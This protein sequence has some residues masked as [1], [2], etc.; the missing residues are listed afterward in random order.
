MA[1]VR[2]TV[3]LHA[4]LV[5]TSVPIV[6]P[7]VWVF[8]T[9]FKTSSDIIRATPTL[10]PERWTMENY[11]SLTTTAPFARFFLNSLLISG[12]STIF[13]IATCSAAGFVFAKYR[14]RGKNFFLLLI[15][16]TILIP[17][18]TYMIP[19][20]LLT[21]WLGWIDTYQG[22]IFPLIIM[23]SGIFFLRQNILGIPD[24]LLDA[25]RIDG[26]SEFGVYW[27]IILPLTVSPLAAVSIVNWV[28]TW[29]VFIWPLVVANR[30]EMFTMELGLM[31]FQRQFIT[32]Y[33]GI[34]AA[35]VVTILPVLVVFLLF[36][37]RIIEGVAYTGMKT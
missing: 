28:Y 27:R 26:A 37:T 2:R 14:F 1:G 10:L 35:T 33:G 36:R 12:V 31:Y 16:S 11:A 17:L 24:D 7:L 18:Q 22:M 30:E 20:Y 13:V 29:S 4:V 21:R 3:F 8:L 25:A 19:L 6:F 34:M 5:G 9:S 32:E 23:S 15:I